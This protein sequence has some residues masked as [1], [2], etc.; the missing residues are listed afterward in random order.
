MKFLGPAADGKNLMPLNFQYVDDPNSRKDVLFVSYR[1]LDTDMKYTETISNPNIEVYIVKPEYRGVENIAPSDRIRDF[2]ELK[3]LDKVTVR[4]RNR[5]AEVAKILNIN[6]E[7]VPSC[8]YVL[9]I[10]VKIEHFYFAQF[11]LEYG[12]SL[13][14]TPHV[15]FA[16]IE[17]EIK[18]AP[19]TGIAPAGE[20]PISVITIIDTYSMKS[21]T[22]ALNIPEYGGIK[23]F[24][25]EANTVN[26]IE[27]LNESFDAVYGHIDYELMLFGTEV[28]LLNAF[29]KIVKVFDPDFLEFWN[30]PFDMSN[31]IQRAI[32]LGENPAEMAFDP[33]SFNCTWYDFY[34]DPNKIIHKRKHRCSL[35]VRTIIVDQ[36]VNYA[37]IRSSGSK[38]PD[39]KLNTIADR[40]LGDKKVEYAEDY[41]SIADFPYKDYR[42][43]IKYNIKD[44][45]LQVGIEAKTRDTTDIYGRMYDFAVM[46]SEV[47]TTTTIVANHYRAE[48]L[49]MGKVMHNN[50][51]K[52][53]ALNSDI[54]VVYDEMESEEDDTDEDIS[55]ALESIDSSEM[56]IDENGKKIK[57]DGAIVL[58][59]T[60]MSTSG[61]DNMKYIHNNVIDEDIG[62][63][64]PSSIQIT[65]LSNETFIGK[66]ELDDDMELPMYNY[67][68]A[69]KDEEAQ[70]KVNVAALALETFAGGDILL[71]AELF[72]GLPSPTD[73]INSLDLSKIL[74][75]NKEKE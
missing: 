40:E 45:L 16:D 11:K 54:S 34:E 68:F 31:I 48:L 57:F 29:W 32:K 23:E 42:R 72:L 10:D 14:K 2:I 9:G 55:D 4:Y 30:M 65:N 52:M 15:A 24:W 27:E 28:D 46:A 12:N 60:R 71:G 75:N 33:T 66:V 25:E 37:V 51:N 69:N 47:A 41:G 6:K 35:P 49:K 19:Y 50:K 74:I 56:F 61:F 63:E 7:D 17:T 18:Y 36:M 53:N 13:P 62:A 43:F 39:F 1:D 67:S 3:Y 22:L 44:V 20:V 70:Y 21:F 8:P 64:Y 5:K 59:P 73:V 26:F 58:N 38:I